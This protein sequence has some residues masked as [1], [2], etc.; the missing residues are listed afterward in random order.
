[1]TNL[2]VTDYDTA[3]CLR[4]AATTSNSQVIAPF[5]FFD[6]NRGS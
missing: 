2:T 1:M 4:F 6:E 3:A 5:A